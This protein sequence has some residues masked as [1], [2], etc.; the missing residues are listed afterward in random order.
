VAT[1]EQLDNAESF[2]R[3]AFPDE[4]ADAVLADQAGTNPFGAL[5]Y[6]LSVAAFNRCDPVAILED[7]LQRANDPDDGDVAAV[8]VILGFDSPAAYV[9][10]RLQFC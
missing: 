10:S 7:F 9:T 8:E 2:V 6:R 1:Q 5:A 4:L 3:E